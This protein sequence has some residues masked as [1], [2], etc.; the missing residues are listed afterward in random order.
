[1]TNP[2]QPY[3]Y[4]ALTVETYNDFSRLGHPGKFFVSIVPTASIFLTG[5]Y[6]GAGGILPASGAAGTAYLSG[7][8]TIDVSDL[9]VGF[10]HELSISYIENPSNIYVLLRNQLVR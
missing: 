1:M 9:A 8:G 2:K 7:G 3:D 10:I 4:P 5:S 6:Y